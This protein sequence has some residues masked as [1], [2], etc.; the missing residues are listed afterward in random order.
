MA[1]KDHIHHLL[2]NYKH[3]M[4]NPDDHVKLTHLLSEHVDYGGSIH[5]ELV[6]K[7]KNIIQHFL[8]DPTLEF[9]ANYSHALSNA[10]AVKS[11]THGNFLKGKDYTGLHNNQDFSVLTDNYHLVQAKSYEFM[12]NNIRF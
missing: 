9:A 7:K 4:A 12:N 1:F 3:V 10:S 5:P 11:Q 8:T 2:K 6:T